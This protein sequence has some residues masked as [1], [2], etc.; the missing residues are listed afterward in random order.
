MLEVFLFAEIY[1]NKPCK[2]QCCSGYNGEF[3]CKLKI[4]LSHVNLQSLCSCAD[5]QTR[6]KDAKLIGPS[7]IPVS[8]TQKSFGIQKIKILGV[9]LQG[10]EK[11]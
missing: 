9:I 3:V 5:L 7:S 10:Q 1:G 2:K 6:F 4:N 8:S 11:Q